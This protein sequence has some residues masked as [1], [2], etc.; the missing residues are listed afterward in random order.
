MSV[1]QNDIGLTKH[2][3][4]WEVVCPR[5]SDPFYIVT[6]YIRWVTTSWTQSMDAYVTSMVFDSEKNE[7]V[8]RKASL[9]Q[10]WPTGFSSPAGPLLILSRGNP[11][12]TPH[13]PCIRWWKRIFCAHMEENKSFRRKK[14]DLWLVSIKSNIFKR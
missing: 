6:Y 8:H 12:T 13:G 14:F 2:N 4:E 5:S 11:P 1:I 3:C 7:H 9:L 10:S